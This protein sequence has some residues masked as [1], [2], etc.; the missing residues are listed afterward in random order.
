MASKNSTN[1]KPKLTKKKSLTADKDQV[2]MRIKESFNY[3]PKKMNFSQ[4]KVSKYFSST[5]KL[6]E[7]VDKGV[8][9][10]LEVRLSEC[11]KKYF[12]Y[13]R[14]K[15]ETQRFA[16]Q[17]IAKRVGDVYVSMPTGAGKSLCFQL[18]ALV[19]PGVSI[20]ISPL[21]ALIYDQVE[22]LKSKGVYLLQ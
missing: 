15:S 14:F 5:K 20:V 22:Q 10:P 17:E 8:V 1:S 13:D 21:I 18:P 11:L 6:D 9:K 2:N 19:R 16:C 4:A 3:K 12:G 7:C